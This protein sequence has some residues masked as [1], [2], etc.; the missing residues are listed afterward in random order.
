MAYDEEKHLGQSVGE[1][2][3][4]VASQSAFDVGSSNKATL[5][6][7]NA[8]NDSILGKLRAFETSLDKK[9]GIESQAINRV[10]PE[11]KVPQLWHHQA[12]M[13]LLWAG[14]TMNI[15]CFSTGLLGWEFGLDFTQSITITI[16]GTLLGSMVSGWCAI[17]GPGTGLRQISISRYSFGWWPSKLV[18]ALNVI[19]QI[20]WS[21]VGCITGGSALSA[22]SS[23]RIGP[24]PGIIIIAVISS[25][26]NLCGLKMILSYEKGAWFVFF[27]VFMVMYG[28]MAP[29]ADIKTKSTLAGAD[30]H[31]QVL[32]L[33]A[34]VYGSSVSWASVAADYYVQY[35]ITTSKT[36]VF[37]L[38]TMGIT[39]STCI[40]MVLGC[41]VGSTLAVNEDLAN[42]YNNEGVGFLIQAMMY[43]RGFAKFILVI[44]VLAGI[45]MNCINLYSCAL[46][47][48]QFAR[49]FARVPRFLWTILLFGIIIGIAIGGREHLNAYLQNF[50]SLLGYWATSFF[51]IIYIEHYL[52]RK[53]RF[54]NYDLDGWNDP[55]RLPMGIA[56]LIAF[57][58]GVVGWVLG[59]VETWFSGPLGLLI[60]SDGGDIANELCLVFTVVTY[61][62]LRYLELRYIGR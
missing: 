22:A 42:T 8:T 6:Y 17:L 57:L 50:L 34:V 44:L 25:V 62:P 24:I 43:P 12:M 16:F 53:G 39:I 27:V 13:A 20:G 4:K 19:S 1:D 60:G 49:P 52:F 55:K 29:K 59:M 58:I 36:K 14:C 48:Q 31:G 3:R 37:I 10:L 30:L 28:E 35:P 61:I 45:G 40:G 21:S 2:L 51:V 7:D 9:F 15:S 11:E 18:A 56:G 26:I 32:S 47:V 46:S 54:E 33:L 5:E 41:C 38:T 23:G